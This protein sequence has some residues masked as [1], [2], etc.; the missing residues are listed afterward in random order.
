MPRFAKCHSRYMRALL[1]LWDGFISVTE[2][3]SGWLLFLTAITG[4]QGFLR[5]KKNP[6][7]TPAFHLCR[8]PIDYN[9]KYTS[10]CWLLGLPITFLRDLS[11]IPALYFKLIPEYKRKV[12]VCFKRHLLLINCFMQCFAPREFLLTSRSSFSIGVTLAAAGWNMVSFPHCPELTAPKWKTAKKMK[13][14][15]CWNLWR[16]LGWQNVVTQTGSWP[17]H[18][19]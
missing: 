17:G 19:D 9:L 16:N 14:A 3:P 12:Q 6:Y 7:V 18:R 1:Q 2:S 4:C 10:L 5:W 13:I 15:S 8:K 11:G